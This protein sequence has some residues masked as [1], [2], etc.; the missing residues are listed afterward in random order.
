[1]STPRSARRR[2]RRGAGV[3]RWLVRLAVVGVVFA[4]GVALGQALEDRPVPGE[5]V[6]SVTTI[7][8]WTQTGTTTSP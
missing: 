1:M 2:R 5:P 4:L 3:V 7:Q 8:P 6:T